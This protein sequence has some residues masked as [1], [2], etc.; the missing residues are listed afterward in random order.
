MVKLIL[1]DD[2]TVVRSGIKMV[3]EGNPDIKIIGEAV[4][5]LEVMDLLKNGVQPDI[6]LTDLNMPHMSGMDLL[7]QVTTAYPEIRM[8]IL[9]MVN[10]EITVSSAFENGAGG[11]LLKHVGIDEL[12]FAIN[13]VSG[14]GMYLSTDLAH[15]FFKKSVQIL[16]EPK[17]RATEVAFTSRELEILELLS[18]GYTNVEMGE[19]LFLSVRTVE[20]HR[21]SLIDKTKSKNTAVL[22]KYAVIHGLVS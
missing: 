20:G 14:G 12:I 11:Y 10:D 22:I 7:K 21:Q 9:T 8:I 16:N 19:K 18:D 13:H 6:I 17:E 5:G 4:S 15:Y 2:H 1:A 3:L